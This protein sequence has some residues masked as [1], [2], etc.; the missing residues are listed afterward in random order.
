MFKSSS[1]KY[2]EQTLKRQE[3]QS[4]NKRSMA[5]W[6]GNYV[7]QCWKDNDISKQ[8]FNPFMK[9]KNIPDVLLSV[10]KSIRFR[11]APHYGVIM[12]TS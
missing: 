3:I 11:H 7:T 12:H 6:L 2:I 9:W 10:H 8:N 4:A 5:V 1:P